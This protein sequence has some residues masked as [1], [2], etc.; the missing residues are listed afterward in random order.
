MRSGS[1]KKKRKKSPGKIK[2]L[3]IK[4]LFWKGKHE[5]KGRYEKGQ[6]SGKGVGVGKFYLATT[7][8]EKKRVSKKEGKKKIV[9]T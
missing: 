5:K 7:R 3:N 2:T 4:L 6:R 9:G 8:V 1:E